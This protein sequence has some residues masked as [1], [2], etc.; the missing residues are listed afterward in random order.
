[1]NKPQPATLARR[2]QL[3]EGLPLAAVGSTLSRHQP[4]GGTPPAKKMWRPPE[5][6]STMAQGHQRQGW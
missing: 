3:Q 2:P 5:A 1:M 6:K 4:S